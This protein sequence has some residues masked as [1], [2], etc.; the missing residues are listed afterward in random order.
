LGIEPAALETREEEGR[1]RVRV[2]KSWSESIAEE[3]RS[4][5]ESEGGN[6]RKLVTTTEIGM[7]ERAYRER[8][9]DGKKR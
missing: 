3:N 9:L 6:G 1:R 8:N 2:R 4:R 5:G 7:A